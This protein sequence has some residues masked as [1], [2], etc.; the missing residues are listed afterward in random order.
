MSQV[1]KKVL[2]H[3]PVPLTPLQYGTQRR[4]LGILKYFSDR[5]DSFSVHVVA[6]NQY[7]ETWVNPR[8]NEGQKQE[9][10]KLVDEVFV[11]QGKSNFYD[12]LYSRCQTLYY[13]K[14]LRKEIPI[15]S[16]YY[17]PPGYVGL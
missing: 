16:D 13:N 15:D 5:K 7:R 1:K 4:I 12:Q 11:Y 2:F 9:T 6:G 10:L 14:L 8:W 3:L 17:T